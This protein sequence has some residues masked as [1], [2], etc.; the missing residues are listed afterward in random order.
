LKPIADFDLNGLI[1]VGINEGSFTS[2][3][4]SPK[5]GRADYFGTVVNRAARVAVAAEPGQA[6]L[7]TMT[8]E[9]PILESGLESSFLRRQTLKGVQGEMALFTCDGS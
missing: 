3:G 9:I 8:D 6:W 7:G 5:T 4:P 1:K 2:T